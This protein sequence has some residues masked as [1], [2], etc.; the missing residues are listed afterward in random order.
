MQTWVAQYMGFCFFITLSQFF[1]LFFEMDHFISI[2]LL[3]Q[4]DINLWVKASCQSKKLGHWI[5]SKETWVLKN[6]ESN[7]V[8]TW[9][10]PSK[11]LSCCMSYNC[12]HSVQRC[13]QTSIVHVEN[14][15]P[16]AHS[17]VEHKSPTINHW[18]GNSN[19]TIFYYFISSALWVGRDIINGSLA[20][21]RFQWHQMI[22]IFKDVPIESAVTGS[23]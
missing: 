21:T 22:G 20:S 12:F 17:P 13:T 10:T 1:F 5:R 8:H 9:V 18:N 4:S 6:K 15:F 19:C 14:W 11:Y 3:E 23:L 2:W 7:K 16:G